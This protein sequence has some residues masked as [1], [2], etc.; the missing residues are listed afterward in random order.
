MQPLRAVCVTIQFNP[1][2]AGRLRGAVPGIQRT[3]DEI[4]RIAPV[5]AWRSTNGEIASWLIAS[6]KPLRAIRALIESPG[7]F[8]E[9]TRWPTLTSADTIVLL[10]VSGSIEPITGAMSVWFRKLSVE[11]ERNRS[12]RNG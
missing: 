5:I 9:T 2:D 12:S 1:F 4:S 7:H 8:G 6:D 10:E 11:V 3:L